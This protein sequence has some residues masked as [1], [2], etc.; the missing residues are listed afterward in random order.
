LFIVLRLWYSVVVEM[1]VISVVS[2]D[3]IILYSKVSVCSLWT[4]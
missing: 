2:Y 3:I 1:V 4:L